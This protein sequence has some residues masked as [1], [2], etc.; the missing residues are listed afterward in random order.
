MNLHIFDVSQYIAAGAVRSDMFLGDVIEDGGI[1]R[2]KEMPVGGV[3]F[4][5]NTIYEFKQKENELVF[6]FDSTPRIKREMHEKAFPSLGGYKGKRPKKL[7][8]IILQRDLAYDILS[9][10]GFNCIRVDGYEADDCIAAIVDE[11]KNSYEHVY[12]HNRDSDLFFLV[13]ENVSIAPVGTQGKFITL[14]NY[15]QNVS[16]KWDIKYNTVLL[17][18]L[19]DGDTSDNIPRVSKDMAELIE[20][21]ITTDMYPLCGKKEYLRKWVLAATNADKQTMAVVDLILTLDVP[22]FEIQLH[23][24]YFDSDIFDYFACALGH[25]KA[26]NSCAEI[27]KCK[28]LL[29]DY[30]DRYT[31]GD[32]I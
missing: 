32:Y 14:A 30:L 31:G 9:M 8:G 29:D 19:Y 6:V 20:K 26:V 22:V 2:S 18:K 11:Y 13:E 25:R 17:S 3:K 7:P 21:Y 16:S 4:L 10:C 5:L 27:S 28:H 15:E 12:V 1:Y 24:T 23:E